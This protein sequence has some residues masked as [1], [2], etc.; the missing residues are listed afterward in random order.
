MV[1]EMQPPYT[2]DNDTN[3]VDLPH[4]YDPPVIVP[5]VRYDHH[6]NQ[7]WTFL[8]LS[9]LMTT[10]SSTSLLL[11]DLDKFLQLL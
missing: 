5:A 2:D 11:L 10:D 1:K 7:T 4:H 6:E 3:P 9:L 8:I